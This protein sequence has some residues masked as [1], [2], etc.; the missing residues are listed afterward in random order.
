MLTGVYPT[1]DVTSLLDLG[2]TILENNIDFSIIKNKKAREVLEMILVKDAEKR[3][4]LLDL[5]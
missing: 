5:L 1:G 3:A 4:S 2:N